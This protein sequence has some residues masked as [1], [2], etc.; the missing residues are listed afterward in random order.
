MNYLIKFRWQFFLSITLGMLLLL[1]PRFII[2]P[3]NNYRFILLPL[4]FILGFTNLLREKQNNQIYLHFTDF[5]WFI[6][7]GIGFSSFFWAINGSLVWFYAFGWLGLILWMLLFR[8]LIGEYDLFYF[9]PKLF[10]CISLIIILHVFLVLIS[11]QLSTVTINWQF[12]FGDNNNYI[13]CYLLSL[14]P[15][16]LFYQDKNR[17]TLFFVLKFL[18]TLFIIFIIFRNGTKGAIICIPFIVL[19][20]LWDVLSRKYFNII[21]LLGLLIFVGFAYSNSDQVLSILSFNQIEG[22]GNTTRFYM[23]ISSIKIFLEHPILG[24]GLGNWHVEAYKFDL[25]NVSGFNHPFVFFRYGSHNLFAQYLVELGLAGFLA[26]IF[27]FVVIIGNGFLQKRQLFPIQKAAFCSLLIYLITSLFYRDV[28]IYEFHFSSIQ[29]LSFCCLG[30]LSYNFSFSNF[31]SKYLKFLFLSLAFLC[32]IWFFFY[33]ITYDKYLKVN[34]MSKWKV[35]S[36]QKIT[37]YDSYFQYINIEQDTLDILPLIRG[38]YH[39]IFK[40]THLYNNASLGLNKSL[41]LQLA[42][43]YQNRKEYDKAEIY[44]EKALK[45]AP[46]SEYVLLSYAKFLLRIKSDPEKAVI[47][48]KKAYQIQS[49]HYDTNLLLAEIAIKNHKY[50]D[51]LVHLEILEE[52][53]GVY[54]WLFDILSADAAIGEENYHKAKE[55]LKNFNNQPNWYDNRIDSLTRRINQAVDPLPF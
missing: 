44:F 49:N 3:W 4:F 37:E 21:I 35:E 32:I 18:L 42:Q 41:S 52:A 54:G 27:P 20:Y 23:L 7:L 14:F 46:Y 25:S 10:F 34:T 33:K 9:L 43:I 30:I 13:P 36:I 24:N 28:S 51:A 26:L 29:F 12:H 8:N 5:S 2:A 55:H 22:S 31:S 11:G 1:M 17:N 53:K 40:T 6:F 38:I 15:F 19:Y 48:A 50:K 45:E 39:P 16:I 47:Y